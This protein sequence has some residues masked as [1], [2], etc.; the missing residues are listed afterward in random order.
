MSKEMRV[1]P[2]FNAGS[3]GILMDDLPDTPG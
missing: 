3:D 2:L 1:D